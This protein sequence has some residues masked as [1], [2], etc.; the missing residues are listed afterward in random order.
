MTYLFQRLFK[1][2]WGTFSR[3]FQGLFFV[4]SNIHSQKK[5]KQW[6]FQIRHT[7][8]IWSCSP[9]D[10]CNHRSLFDK[11]M[12]FGTGVVLD[13]TWDIS[14]DAKLNRSKICYFGVKQLNSV[15]K[16]ARNWKIFIVSTFVDALVQNFAQRKFIT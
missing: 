4:L 7:E 16:I 8:T 10:Y 14:Y 2:F 11:S 5:D 12:K 1:D 6:I 13:I 15:Q 9:A 3:S